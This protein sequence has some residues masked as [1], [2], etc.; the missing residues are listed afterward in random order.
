M[1][2]LAQATGTAAAH[3]R[4]ALVG[5]RARGL[6][7]ALE[8]LADPTWWRRCGTCAKP[9]PTTGAEGRLAAAVQRGEDVVLTADG[10]VTDGPISVKAIVVPVFDPL[11]RVIL[12]LSVAGNGELQS[13]DR[14]LELGRRLVRAAAVVTRRSRGRG[15]TTG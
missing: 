15:P 7:I 1:A 9:P 4:S 13:R 14:V 8:A 6:G 5:I 10:L 11:G 12:T 2:E 3:H